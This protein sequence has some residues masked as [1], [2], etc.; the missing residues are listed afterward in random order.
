MCVGSPRV[1]KGFR[2][3]SQAL[4]HARASDTTSKHILQRKLYLPRIEQRVHRTAK[5]R[6]FQNTHGNRKVR[7]VPEV[8]CLDAEQQRLL[9][10]E[11]EIFEDSQIGLG[12][13]RR[14]KRVAPDA[15]V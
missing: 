6:C 8:E 2:L 9:V 11:A 12:H 10:V 1:S 5:A 7:A 14:A 4:A 13:S 15:S 3:S